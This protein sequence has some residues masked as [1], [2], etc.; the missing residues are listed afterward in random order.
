LQG[1]SLQNAVKSAI[2]AVCDNKDKP[3]IVVPYD[4]YQPASLVL[5]KQV[6]FHIYL[7]EKDDE[8]MIK[9]ILGLTK[10]YRNSVLKNLVR[11]YISVPVLAP[12]INNTSL[13]FNQQVDSN[14]DKKKKTTHKAAET[15][16][17]IAGEV[18]HTPINNE[19]K[20]DNVVL[21]EADDVLTNGVNPFDADDPSETD[22]SAVDMFD[23]LLSGFGNI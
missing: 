23:A 18:L 10:G 2:T 22:D 6:Q 19:V 13:S 7:S 16:A 17:D 12:F 8:K 4:E 14:T 21:K 5:P 15:S 9:W 20:E 11:R 3:F 1:F